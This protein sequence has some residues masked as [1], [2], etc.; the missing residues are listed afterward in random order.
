MSEELA[1]NDFPTSGR[2]A[3]VDFGSVRIG[4]AIC[5]P[6]RILASPYEVHPATDW[7]QDGG[8][9]RRLTE[10]ERVVGFVVGLPIH[11]DGGESEKSKQCREFAQWLMKETAVPVRLFDERFTTA[12]AKNRMAGAGYTR[13]KKKKRM[14]AVA[15]FVLLESF[16]EAC[17]YR[18]EIA[19]EP[20]DSPPEG[21]EGLG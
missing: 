1:A 19:G 2:I 17:R 12:D 3:A 16:I 8:Y 9:Y 6:D 15:A 4:I 18:G 5:D 20:V 21:G 11:L 10:S 7:Q 13:S 14:D